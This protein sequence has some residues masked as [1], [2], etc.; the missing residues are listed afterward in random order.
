MKNHWAAKQLYPTDFHDAEW[1]LNYWR[2]AYG[3]EAS[4][5]Y[6][7]Q[8]GPAGPIK[9]GVST[10]PERRLRQHQTSNHE[11]L[12]L[13]YV[14]PG[15]AYEEAGLHSRLQGAHVRGEWFHGNAIPGFCLWLSRHLERERLRFERTGEDPTIDMT[16]PAKGGK[17]LPSGAFLGTGLQSRWR[18]GD[19][20]EHPVTVAHVDPETM[21]VKR[22]PAPQ[23]RSRPHPDALSDK[24][25][26]GK[27][28]DWLKDAA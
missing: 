6:V 4:F 23:P 2:D 12:K 16:P 27:L 18:T 9:V 24:P 13:L 20:R 7:I 14:F 17:G 3:G 26:R 10:N 19:G 11:E 28:P 1:H 5:V 15:D 22:N 21:D 25:W 8:A